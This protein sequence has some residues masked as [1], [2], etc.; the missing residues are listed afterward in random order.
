MDRISFCGG[1][2]DEVVVCS[3]I[4]IAVEVVVEAVSLFSF[5]HGRGAEV[6]TQDLWWTVV[7]F[8]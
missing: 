6:S 2:G 8:G 5:S 1:G 7:G 4:V 3:V